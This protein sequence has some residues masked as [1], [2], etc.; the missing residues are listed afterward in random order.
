M[1]ADRGV[2]TDVVVRAYRTLD[3]DLQK[4]VHEDMQIS[5]SSYP[6]NRGLK[7]TDTNIDHRRVPNLMKFFSRHGTE[8]S[9]TQ[10]AGDYKPGEIICWNLCGTIT[11]VGLVLDRKSSDGKGN[12]IV[13]NVGGSQ[14]LADCLFTYRIIG[15]YRYSG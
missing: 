14:V 9:I 15:H 1:P 3:I 11:N 2:C 10:N 4:E 12:L 8:I 7:R 13:H 5:F 6:K